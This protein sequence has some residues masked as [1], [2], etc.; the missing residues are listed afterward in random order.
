MSEKIMQD[1]ENLMKSIQTFLKKFNRISFGETPKV[2]LRDWE[3]FF[4]IQ[5]AQ[6]EYTHELLRKLLEDLQIISGE[7]AE[8]INSPSW[9][10]PTFYDNDDEYSIQYK[11]YLENF[12]N[13]IAPVLPTEN[14]DN[15]LS[16]GD[17][18]FSTISETES[19][20]EIKSSVE[21]LVPIL[22]FDP[23]AL[24]TKATPVEESTGVLESM[25]D[26]GVIA[27]RF[28]P[29]SV[30]LGQVLENIESKDFYDFNLDEPDLLVT[31]LFDVNK[32]VSFD[33]GGDVDEIND[34]KDGY[35]D[36]KGDI[37][38][39]ERLLNDDLVYHDPSIPAMSVYSIL[40]GFTD[41]PP[42][43]END[44]LF[45]LESKND[46]WKKILYD[47]SILMSG[48]KIFDPRI[49]V[50]FFSPTYVNLTFEDRHYIFFTYVVRILLLYLTYPVV[51]LF[52]LSSF[53]DKRL[54]ELKMM[55][56]MRQ[57]ENYDMLLH[58]VMTDMKL[59]VVEIETADITADD[60][61]KVSCSTDVGRSNQVDLK[62]SH[63][64][65][66]PHLH[67]IH[68]NQDKDEVDRLNSVKQIH[69]IIDGKAMVIS[70]SLV[71]SDL[72]FNDEDGN[73][74]RRQET[75]SGGTDAQTRFAT[76][77]KKSRDLPLSEV[78]TSR[79]KED[80]MEHPHDLTNFVPPTP[81]DSPLSEGYTPRSDE[82]QTTQDKVITRLKLRVRRLEK[83]RKARTSQPM[84]RR[85]LKGRVKTSTDK[86]LGEDTSKQGMNDDKTEELNLTDGA[87]TE[88]IIEDKGSGE[89]GGSTTDQVSTARQEV[90]AASVPVNVS[91]ATPST[92]TTTTIFI[93]EDLTIAQTLIK[94]RSEKAKVKGIAFID[95][96]EPPKLTR[97]TTTLQPLPTIDLKDKA[98]RIYEEEL[99]E[100]DRA[101]KE[102]Q[103]QKEA[104]IAVL[105]KE[106]DEIQARI[107][108]DHELAVRMTHEEQKSIQ[109]KKGQDYSAH[110][111]KSSKKQKMIQES[112]KSDE[113][114]SADYEHEK[115]ELKMWLTI[116]LDK[117]ISVDPKILS[118]KYLI[119]DWES[120][121]LW[122]VD[123]KDLHVYKIIRANMNISYHKSLSSIL[124]KFDRQD[125]VDLHKLVMKRFE[126]NTPEGYNLLLWE[127]LKVMFEQNT[128]DE[129]W[130]NQQDWNLISWKLYENCGVHTLLMDGTL[131]C[132]NM[133]VEKRYPLMKEML[134][135]MLN[136]K[137]EA[138]V[139]STMTFELF[140]FIKSQ[141]EERRDV[142]I[143]PPGDQDDDNKE[144]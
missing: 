95:V 113:E 4:E 41:E 26:E 2:L 91:A 144:T 31:P 70:E 48:D 107:D 129:I 57:T 37:L 46:D 34:F 24:E 18:H 90:S 22:N 53:L 114:E 28:V 27:T 77:S 8:Y 13:A 59:L 117:K 44:D 65:I 93:D 16:L 122:N 108:A 143:H 105:A 126:D 106:F 87:D 50:K 85:L 101:Q 5:H 15:S 103:N 76:A 7:L 84:M 138:K 89:K 1:R 75:T 60:V 21:D 115:E 40:E 74:P 52:L 96:E 124:R 100:L 12:S 109:L 82:A 98:Q 88:V 14:P 140:N 99:A 132:F 78:N 47:A 128:E 133:L 45:D 68:V 119:V 43:K 36:S 42:L 29:R 56:L 121:N 110:K 17:E 66:E 80:I 9:N 58:M 111:R 127:D 51:S 54:N 33:S 86:I 30:I 38:Y 23:L 92:P 137:L 79:S 81:H 39:L 19:N 141:V 67:D 71:T 112:A 83:K 116:V 139:K 142:W 102:K 120:Q 134:E 49:C 11:E 73:R 61:D 123:M 94:L 6:P 131:N 64:S 35:Y 20:E 32:D 136:W 125:L 135:K 25:F 97:S 63:S 130:S 118:T 69:A 10:R 104:T 55:V 3:K 62:F 72:L